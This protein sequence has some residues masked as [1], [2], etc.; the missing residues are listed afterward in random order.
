MK[1]LKF[2]IS[3]TFLFCAITTWAQEKVTITGKVVDVKNVPIPGVTVQEPEN[4]KN[5]AVTDVNGNFRVNASSK[6]AT[7]SF[8]AIS[9]AT[10]PIKLNGRLN[11]SVV[12]KEDVKGLNEVV[13]RAYQTTTRA[14]S[15]GAS[16]SIKA[17][18]VADVPTATLQNT[19]VGRLPGFFSQ[20][21][22][23]QPGADAADFYI[24]GTNSL[25][26]DSQ[27]LI[28]VDDIEYTYAQVAQLDV[29]E[30]ESV[31]ILKD[32][33]TTAVYG[34][35]GANGV[36]LITTK[37][38][39]IGKPKITLT[40]E[41]GVNQVIK[42]TDYM[43]AYTTAVLMNEAYINDSY[44]LSGQKTL[45][46]TAAD[47]QAFKDGTDPYG[48]PNV[49]WQ[50]QLLKNMSTQQR[51]NVD[52]SGGNNIVKYMTS[53]GYFSQDGLLKHFAP[54]KPDDDVNNNYFYNRFN[55]RSNLDITPTKTLNLQF[56]INGRFETLNNPAGVQE[57]AGLFKQLEEFKSLA[58]LSMPVVN[59]N[60]TYGYA[61]QIGSNGFINPIAALA[62]GG[63][64]RN[65][66]NNFN[67]TFRGTQKLD[68]ITQGLDAGIIVAYS[69]NINEHRN[70]SRAVASQIPVYF[71]NS[72]TNTYNLKSGG[73]AQLPPYNQAFGNDAFNNNTN[74]RAQLHYKRQFGEHS[75][76]VVALVNQ[77]SY[78]NLGNVPLNYRGIS[79][80]LNYVFKDRYILYFTVAKNGN[81]VFN[82]NQ[83][84]GV[85]PAA[86]IAYD[87]SK[88]K[89]FN[90]LF[91]FFDLFKIRGSYGING[92]DKSYTNTN[93]T[94]VTSVVQYSLPAAV[95]YFGNGANEGALVNPN[96][97]WEKERK[98][99]IGLD[100][101]MFNGKLTFSPD[102][103]YNYRYD[104]L[105]AQGDVP[106]L[107]GQA[108]PQKN[109]GITSN[110]GFDG[111]LTYHGRIKN[112]DFTVS[113][114]YSHAKNKIIYVSE[115]PNYPY[116]ARSGTQLGSSL[117]YH[118]VGF[119]QASDFDASGQVK[120]GIPK[121]L[122][123]TI[124]PGD[125]KY[126]DLNGDGLI[127]TADQY[128]MSKP[129]LP[130]DTYG[131]NFSVSYKGFSLRGLLQGAFGYSVLI[132]AEGS[133]SFLGNI[134][135]WFVDAWTPSTAATATYPRISFNSAT[136][137]SSYQ[138][139]GANVSS[140]FWYQNASYV[141]L[142]SLELGYQVPAKALEKMFVHSARIYLSGYNLLTFRNTGKF[143]I[144]PEI[145]SGQGNA[146]PITANYI[147]GVQLG[148]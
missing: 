22:S 137:N 18:E 112:V 147:L 146:Y 148:F 34:I 135:P 5:I 19:L 46:Y 26:G 106:L 15:A 48:H 38:G 43:D 88:E 76:D 80:I 126:A 56:D 117:A 32:A 131:L 36:L 60:G 54:V 111:E 65:F 104:Q 16:S 73:T 59:P 8:S 9:F 71:Y 33:S 105:I 121:P 95:S 98:T 69:S 81:D 66:N 67:I 122:W 82:S 42:F 49:N 79:G 2:I 7:L 133:D 78:Q 10:T 70:E 96:I 20:Q 40:G 77:N 144:D 109:I 115:A 116:Q 11:L 63:Y 47:L 24:R 114:N 53:L 87:I 13:V 35:K 17:S 90:K 142:K 102:W 103:F 4:P 44:G 89:F 14:L 55:F 75:F 132:N 37:R 41:G 129:N 138:T 119:Y 123:S 1:I 72:A 52:V 12:L 139:G 51:Y 83:K 23:G 6:T 143:D 62:N 127:T 27:P 94:A 28:I 136:N 30:I 91:P 141:R 31:T 85:F 29:N 74:I 64:N 113:G 39:K 108:L 124:Q 3:L 99:D 68:F 93:P 134:R 58:P 21:R 128:Y 145:A 120:A 97:T 45:P 140:D 125:M 101:N 130:T 92:S 57:S 100:I 50:K 86:S 118:F 110:T 61:S 107:I 25:N 84:Y